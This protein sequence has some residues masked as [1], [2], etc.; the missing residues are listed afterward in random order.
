MLEAKQRQYIK[1]QN[2]L[3]LY[4]EELE[5]K[6]KDLEVS[7][8][9]LVVSTKKVILDLKRDNQSLV[10]KLKAALGNKQPTLDQPTSKV[11]K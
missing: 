9:Q 7:K 4:C 8:N 10:E 1:N 11:R 2:Q 3:K 6:V 5:I